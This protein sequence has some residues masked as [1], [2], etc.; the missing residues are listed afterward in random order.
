MSNTRPVVFIHPKGTCKAQPFYFRGDDVLKEPEYLEKEKQDIKKT[1][2]EVKKELEKQK[3]IY[4]DTNAEHQKTDNLTFALATALGDESDSTNTNAQL[5]HRLAELTTE[6]EGKER[7]ITKLK[8]MQQSAVISTYLKERAFY[9]SEIEDLRI[10]INTGIDRMKEGKKNLAK[11]VCSD[12]YA[13]SCIALGILKAKKAYHNQLRKDLTYRIYNLNKKQ[14]SGIFR[15][16]PPKLPF[17]IENLCDMEQKLKAQYNTIHRECFNKIMVAQESAFA[18]ID[19]IERMNEVLVALGGPKYDVEALREKYTNMQFDAA[20]GE[21]NDNLEEEE[22]EDT[23]DKDEEKHEEEEEKV[24]I[25][26]DNIEE[27]EKKEEEGHKDKDDEQKP[28]EHLE[29]EETK[30]DE[31][32][33]KVNEE[34]EKKEEENDHA[35]EEEKNESKEKSPEEEEKK[36]EE[37]KPVT[38]QSFIANLIQD[39]LEADGVKETD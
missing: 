29:E 34:E 36:E 15:S 20:P 10:E 39:K 3:K 16:N 17:E 18:M 19:Q 1:F 26:D 38:T 33:I 21:E 14:G 22:E 12:D 30:T 6:I 7:A 35:E 4:D 32:D 27:E 8:A 9:E 37:D 31:K 28:E 2:R 11:V 13:T 24:E 5:R 23:N 25:N